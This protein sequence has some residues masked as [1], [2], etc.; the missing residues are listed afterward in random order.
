MWTYFKSGSFY[1]KIRSFC[2]KMFLDLYNRVK[3]K[4]RHFT[5]RRCW[6]NY[7]SVYKTSKSFF[8]DCKCTMDLEIEVSPLQRPLKTC[9]T[10]FLNFEHF[11]NFS[12]TSLIFKVQYR[13]IT[14]QVFEACRKGRFQSSNPSQIQSRKKCFDAFTYI[15]NNL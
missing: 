13:K 15:Y 10:I 11:S 6:I 8:R 14:H 7:I 12:H 4:W 1:L 2:F 3:A 9:C 5:S